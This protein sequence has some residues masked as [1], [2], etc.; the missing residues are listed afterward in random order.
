M[1]NVHRKIFK[2]M[3]GLSKKVMMHAYEVVS[4][5]FLKLRVH[6]VQVYRLKVPVERVVKFHFSIN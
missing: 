2:H 1:I 5:D 4:L 3:E 6:L